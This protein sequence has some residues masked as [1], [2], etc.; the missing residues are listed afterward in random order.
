M[1]EHRG[2]HDSRLQPCKQRTLGDQQLLAAVAAHQDRP[3][4]GMGYASIQEVWPDRERADSAHLAVV[5]L[6]VETPQL[7]LQGL[8]GTRQRQRAVP[9]LD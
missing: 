1:T 2:V 3:D 4:R 8:E 7:A 9:E 5:V 6:P